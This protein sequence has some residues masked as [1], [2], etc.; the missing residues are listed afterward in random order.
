[1]DN[2]KSKF[3]SKYG[4]QV[5]EIWWIRHGESEA[6]AGLATEH[7]GTISLSMVG[8]E[9]AKRIPDLFPTAPD[10]IITSPYLRTKL[11]AQP[12]LDKYP[13]VTHAEWKLHEFT[14]LSAQRLGLT[15]WEQRRPH[16]DAFWEKADPF[17]IDGADSESFAQFVERVQ[18]G[19]ALAR[20]TPAPRI[21]IFT[22]GFVMYLMLWLV[23]TNA[24]TL[25][26]IPMAGWRQ[27]FM[28]FRIPN[29]A[30]IRVLDDGE[31]FYVSGVMI[32]HLM[33]LNR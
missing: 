1:V 2:G 29:G 27:F 14:F 28:S 13:H 20:E 15:T 33:L 5:K 17:A 12:L 8:F 4:A 22:H 11:T 19:L 25:E 32:E 10:L 7:D 3:R 26:H 23:L 24:T 16:A 6:N 18:L 21:V 9:Q 30:A 31:R